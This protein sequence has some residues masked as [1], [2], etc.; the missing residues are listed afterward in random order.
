M[1]KEIKSRLKENCLQDTLDDVVKN[2]IGEIEGISEYAPFVMMLIEKKANDDHNQYGKFL[3]KRAGKVIGNNYF[4]PIKYMTLANHLE[5][6]TRASRNSYRIFPRSFVVSL[7][8]TFDGYIG[9]LLS[10]FLISKPELLNALD[11]SI[12]L[13]QLQQFSC[14]EQAKI[15][16]AEKE[17]ED[18]LRESHLKHFNWMENKFNIVLRKDLTVWPAFIELTERRNLFVHCNG[19]ISRQ[20]LTICKE[21]DVNLEKEFKLGKELGVSPAY[22][23]KAY[24]CVFEIGVKLAHVLWRKLFPNELK[25]ADGNLIDV[26]YDLLLAEN[27]VL[28]KII[29]DFSRN[30][31]KKYHNEESRRVFLINSAIACCFSGETRKG[32]E[33]LNKEDWSSC[34]NSFKL[35][36]AVLNKKYSEAVIIM[37]KIGTKGE[38]QREEY[39]EW[40]LFKN[41]RNT[42]EFKKVY[43]DIFNENFNVKSS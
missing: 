9:K 40:P 43:K 12:S 16:F 18:L 19:I 34:N 35:G 6:R 15:Y 22:F 29:S 26:V 17:I 32:L 31:L 4:L 24:E 39:K 11:K 42:P 3:R 41:F 14:V 2:F 33:I 10:K 28:D 5:R 23:N 21:N 20:Y 7:I 27:Y 1:S 30:T 38:V 37:K 25:Q 13:S 8:S 36:V